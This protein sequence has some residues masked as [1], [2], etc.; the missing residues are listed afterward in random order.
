[1]CVYGGGGGG[2]GRCVALSPTTYALCGV[3]RPRIAHWVVHVC[4]CVKQKGK[5]QAKVMH[6]TT[7]K[8]R[9]NKNIKI[10]KKEG[11]AENYP[12]E[13]RPWEYDG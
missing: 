1:M 10:K 4:L 5:N 3:T 7:K 9:K 11:K 6:T 8:K 12:Q 2:R 13:G